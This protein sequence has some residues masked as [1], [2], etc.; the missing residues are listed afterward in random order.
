[1]CGRQAVQ[2]IETESMNVC[3]DEAGKMGPNDVL[4]RGD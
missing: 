4:E 3:P 2:G 1:L